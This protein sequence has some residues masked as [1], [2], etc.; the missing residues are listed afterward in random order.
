M[1]DEQ[2]EIM[3]PPNPA[4]DARAAEQDFYRAIVEGYRA[5]QRR[6][7]LFYELRKTLVYAC[8]TGLL[9]IGLLKL[10]GWL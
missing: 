2:Q 8:M 4:V 7:K 6:K 5:G 1:I 9:L 10:A 3:I